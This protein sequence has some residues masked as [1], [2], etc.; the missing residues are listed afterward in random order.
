MYEYEN[1]MDRSEDELS[2]Y[3]GAVLDEQMEN[4]GLDAREEAFVRGYVDELYSEESNQLEDDFL[5]KFDE[6]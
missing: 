1:V 4:D 2:V 5:A 3:S 6:A